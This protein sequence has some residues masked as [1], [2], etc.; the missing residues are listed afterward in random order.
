[1]LL[2]SSSTDK[3]LENSAQNTCAGLLLLGK[4]IAIDSHDINIFSLGLV[5]Q[6][7]NR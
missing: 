6:A 3:L 1:M 2:D 4:E 7:I 5:A